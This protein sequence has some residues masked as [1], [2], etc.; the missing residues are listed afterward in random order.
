MNTAYAVSQGQ[1]FNTDTTLEVVECA[2]CSVK[3]AIPKSLNDSAVRYPGN[4]PNGWTI[5]CPFGH[6]W[7]YV[8]ETPEEKLKR[9]R[10][11]SAR[12][13]AELDQMT[14]SRNAY[15]GVATRERA[16]RKRVEERVAHGVCPC[17]KRTF[18]Q[19]AAHMERKHPEYAAG[20]A[21]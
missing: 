19:L 1:R 9:E 14:A 3:Y 5:F 8:G 6:S 17:C 18:K 12:V 20:E 11:R 13:T 4:R 7:H 2:S 16:A 15:K 10:E 21:A